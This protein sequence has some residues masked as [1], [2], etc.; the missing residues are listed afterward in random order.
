ML[1][2]DMSVNRLQLHS[3]MSLFALHSLQRHR[4][5]SCWSCQEEIQPTLERTSSGIWHVS[6]A[7]AFS[8]VCRV[9][10]CF[11]YSAM[12]SMPKVFHT[13]FSLTSRCDLL[14]RSSC[15]QSKSHRWFTMQSFPTW[16]ILGQCVT[17]MQPCAQCHPLLQ[18]YPNTEPTV[19]QLLDFQTWL[20]AAKDEESSRNADY[21]GML[22]CRIVVV[23]TKLC[24]SFLKLN[25]SQAAATAIRPY[26]RISTRCSLRATRRCCLIG[27][28]ILNDYVVAVRWY[29]NCRLLFRARRL[30]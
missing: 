2:N 20:S 13:T 29:V 16:C 10:W 6:V 30:K 19:P 17:H 18:I 23:V 4:F 22:F 12:N 24:F 27:D 7:S 25:L 5:Q 1:H 11:L 9:F 15:A 3:I 28:Q 14:D 26:C 21:A 8:T